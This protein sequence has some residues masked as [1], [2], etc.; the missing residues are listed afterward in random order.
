MAKDALAKVQMSLEFR[1]WISDAFEGMW[2]SC[3]KKA[4]KSKKAAECASVLQW[5][6]V[7]RPNWTPVYLTFWS[8]TATVKGT[9]TTNSRKKERQIII[10]PPTRNA[11][12]IA[13]RLSISVPFDS[14]LFIQPIARFLAEPITAFSTIAGYLLHECR[15]E[16]IAMLFR[17]AMPFQ[18]PMPKSI[19][20]FWISNFE[21]QWPH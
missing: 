8:A 17:I 19:Q 6:E 10:A 5:E 15:S 16:A 18:I 21:P 1:V 7:L 4:K 12:T 11:S 13:M 9:R 14:A 3:E 2:N 20:T